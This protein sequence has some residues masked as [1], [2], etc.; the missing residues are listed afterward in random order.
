[1][2]QFCQIFKEHVSVY[3]IKL[4]NVNKTTWSKL[5]KVEVKFTIL[6]YETKSYFF[7]ILIYT[8]LFVF[9]LYSLTLLYFY[10]FLWVFI[11]FL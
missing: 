4:S 3:M 10:D 1:M 2:L 9:L 6:K 8:E 5:K 11:F 7:Y